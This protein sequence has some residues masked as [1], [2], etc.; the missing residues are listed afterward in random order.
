MT[1]SNDPTAFF[2]YDFKLFLSETDRSNDLIKKIDDVSTLISSLDTSTTS[3]RIMVPIGSKAFMP[4][5]LSNP[6]LFTVHLGAEFYAEQTRQQVNERLVRLKRYTENTKKNLL[7]SFIK[8]Y[9]E[10]SLV[11]P[12]PSEHVSLTGPKLVPQRDGTVEIMEPVDYVPEPVSRNIIETKQKEI[13][14]PT[15]PVVEKIPLHSLVVSEVVER[16]PSEQ[17][18]AS[19]Y[20]KP[21][22]QQSE[23]P[24]RVS[25]FKKERLD[26]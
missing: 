12:S 10:I 3:R 23:K 8:K 6:S 19:D 15:S 5:T 4:G 7:D 20:Q 22:E 16:L 17:K 18:T 25:K 26:K 9:G 11:E 13:E 2:D 21:S 14:S 24:Q 1:S